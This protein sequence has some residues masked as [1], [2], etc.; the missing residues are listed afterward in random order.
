MKIDTL[1]NVLEVL[2]M[3]SDTPLSAAKLCELVDH[4]DVT[5]KEVKLALQELSNIY[6]S[7]GIGLKKVASGYRFQAKEEYQEWFHKLFSEKPAK[8]SRALLETLA[9]VAYRQ[10][11]TRA[12]VESI[13][14][15][16]VSTSIMRTL[17]ER[18]WVKVVGHRDVP[19][20]PSIYAT[21]KG[22][23]DYFN[24]AK[25]DDLPPLSEVKEL[26]DIMEQGKQSEVNLKESLD[27]QQQRLPLEEEI[28]NETTEP[29]TSQEAEE[30]I[31]SGTDSLDKE[32]IATEQ[33]IIIADDAVEI[34]KTDETIAIS[35]DVIPEERIE[36]ES[37]SSTFAEK[38]IEEVTDSTPNESEKEEEVVS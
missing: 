10:P 9:I 26:A 27:E 22:F 28:N 2:I 8:Y 33:E 15:V 6:E 38:V 1:M 11:V 29:T 32:R 17:L 12:D 35:S 31:E 7:R 18:D 34:T 36:E 16:A 5:I 19:G 24:L 20:K 3:V 13:R 4:H 14:G 30:A 25:L 23:L 21:T 37:V